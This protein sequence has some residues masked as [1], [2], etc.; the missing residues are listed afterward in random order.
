MGFSGNIFFI[1]GFFRQDFANFRHS[2]DLLSNKLDRP[3]LLR[4]LPYEMYS[5]C[6]MIS[7]AWKFSS[8]RELCQTWHDCSKMDL[9]YKT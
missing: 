5:S 1:S 2:F 9:T 8:V 3:D 6:N 4:A 7:R